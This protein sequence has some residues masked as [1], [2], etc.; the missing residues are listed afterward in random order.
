MAS[1]NQN[2]S[3]STGTPFPV[4]ASLSGTTTTE[5]I[6]TFGTDGW[7]PV[8]VPTSTTAED[9]VVKRETIKTAATD[10]NNNNNNG[11]EDED[12][13]DAVVAISLQVVQLV[14][15]VAALAKTN[16]KGE[17][18]E[19]TIN[20]KIKCTA[21]PRADWSGF[22]IGIEDY[23]LGSHNPFVAPNL[24]PPPTDDD[25]DDDYYFDAKAGDDDDDNA[26]TTAEDESVED[27]DDSF[28]IPLTCV[29]PP[30]ENISR[31]GK[32]G[33]PFGASSGGSTTT[34]YW[35]DGAI[36]AASFAIFF[37]FWFLTSAPS[38]SVP[39]SNVELP[40]V[41]LPTFPTFGESQEIR[42]EKAK[43]ARTSFNEADSSAKEYE[44]KTKQLR[45]IASDKER[46]AM[47]AK[48]E[49]CKTRFGGNFLCIRPF[50]SGY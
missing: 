29:S 40:K 14:A 4:G 5:A 27:D 2:I 7:S 18:L 30:K 20:S 19:W 39:K 46:I 47:S 31:F 38:F 17:K 15:A 12:E 50:G 16:Q 43:D 33:F 48:E 37:L 21:T 36:A 22:I 35:S 34:Y 13:D 6:P 45:D 44:T 25:D 23:V 11:D 41:S 3:T 42:D 10:N 24:P 26:S 9:E 8:P 49:A 1:N 32:K 28:F